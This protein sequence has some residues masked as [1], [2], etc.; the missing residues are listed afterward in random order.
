MTRPDDAE[1]PEKPTVHTT[2]TG[3]QWVDA[4]EL[5]QS[6]AGREEIKRSNRAM[7]SKEA[8]RHSQKSYTGEAMKPGTEEWRIA[9]DVILH[10]HAKGHLEA[11][12]EVTMLMLSETP[13]EW[14]EANV[15]H[16]PKK[17][18]MCKEMRGRFNITLAEAKRIADEHWPKP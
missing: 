8:T 2:F 5:V 4:D 9:R 12:M 11:A 18:D 14:A 10:L 13:E 16:Y 7:Q 17:L 15:D 6:K 1:R 3:R